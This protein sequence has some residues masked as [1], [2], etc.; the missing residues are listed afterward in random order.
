MIAYLFPFRKQLAP[1]VI[2]PIPSPQFIKRIDRRL[3]AHID[4]KMLAIQGI[5]YGANHIGFQ[6]R[7]MNNQIAR[8]PIGAVVHRQF[9]RQRLDECPRCSAPQIQAGDQITFDR[10]EAIHF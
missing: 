5:V 9:R 6:G 4:T 10:R 3:P 7:Q 2:R 8:R 1:A